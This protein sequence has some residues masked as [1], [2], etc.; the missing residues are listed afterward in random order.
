MMEDALELWINEIKRYNPRL[1]L[2]GPGLLDG[3]SAHVQAFLPLLEHIQSPTVA[4]LG[5]GSG[6]PGI[7][8]ALTH[9]DTRVDLIERAS[10]KCVFLRHVVDMLGLR[11]VKILE[12][13]PLRNELPAYAAVMARAFSPKHDL[14]QALR[15]LLTTDGRFYALGT[16]APLLDDDF[17]SRGILS[18]PEDPETT[19]FEYVFRPK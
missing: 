9:P 18:S 11:K 2:V 19:L 13:D 14:N 8:Y 1:H 5:S 12:V 10:D 16:Q 15:R 6:L 17:L 7:P 3:L 4:D